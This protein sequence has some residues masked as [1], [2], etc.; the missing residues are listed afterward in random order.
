MK[1]LVLQSSNDSARED[2][3]IL[4]VEDD[5]DAVVIEGFAERL[6]AL[7]YEQALRMKSKY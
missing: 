7:L 4:K 5:N 6:A 2:S 3:E 1:E